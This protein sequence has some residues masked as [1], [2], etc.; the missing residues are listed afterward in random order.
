[1]WLNS[2]NEMFPLF[3]VMTNKQVRFVQFIHFSICKR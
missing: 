2:T 1:M 3:Y